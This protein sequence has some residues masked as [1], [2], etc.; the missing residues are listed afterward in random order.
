MKIDVGFQAKMYQTNGLQFTFNDRDF[1]KTD[2]KLTVMPEMFVQEFQPR[3]ALIMTN[4][5]VKMFVLN[6][7][8]DN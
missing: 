2:I 7:H 1:F 5:Q 3:T 4:V 6:V 8:F